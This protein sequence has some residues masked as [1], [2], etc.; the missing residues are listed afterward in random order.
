MEITQRGPIQRTNI[1]T[2][3]DQHASA[4]RP[5]QAHGNSTDLLGGCPGTKTKQRKYIGNYAVSLT[6]S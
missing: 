1:L 2:Q 5:M 6:V 3:P 4:G